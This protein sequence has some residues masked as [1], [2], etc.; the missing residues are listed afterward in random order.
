MARGRDN[1]LASSAAARRPRRR[2]C[3]E[4]RSLRRATSGPKKPASTKH[5]GRAAAGCAP[6]AACTSN[7]GPYSRSVA[8]AGFSHF[9]TGFDGDRGRLARQLRRFEVHAV[10]ETGGVDFGLQR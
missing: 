4:S 8:L 5:V 10:P 6:D 1:D 2:Q 3:S 9:S 7:Q